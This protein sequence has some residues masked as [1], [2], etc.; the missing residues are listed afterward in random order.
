MRLTVSFTSFKELDKVAHDHLV[1]IGA[2][3]VNAV[4]LAHVDNISIVFY[5]DWYVIVH[6]VN[7]DFSMTQ[8]G[9]NYYD[10]QSWTF[11]VAK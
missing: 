11:D 7:K 5:M 8:L 1:I 10:V 9:C 2:F 6:V 4:I 3:L